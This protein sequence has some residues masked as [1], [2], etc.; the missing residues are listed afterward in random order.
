MQVIDEAQ[1]KNVTINAKVRKGH[2]WNPPDEVYPI[3]LG[4]GVEVSAP[5]LFFYDSN[6]V[7]AGDA[8]VIDVASVSKNDTV[9]YASIVG[10]AASVVTIGPDE[11]G[12]T[13]TDPT[14][15]QVAAGN[16][17]YI[18]NASVNGSAEIKIGLT[19]FSTDTTAIT[20]AGGGG[21]V[22]GQDKSAAVTGTVTIGNAGDNELTDGWN[23]IVCGTGNKTG[24]TITD[25]TLKG[26]TSSVVIEGQEN[27]DI[28]AED[29]ASITLN[30]HPVIGIPPNDAGFEQ[31]PDKP[32]VEQG[33]NINGN[34]G[35]A[36][37]L[38]GFASVTFNNGTVQCIAGD[39][40]DLF[41]TK[42]GTPT[43]TLN[44]TTIQNTEYGVNA[45]AGTAT[46]S[47][48]TIWY[49]YNGVQQGTDGTNVSSIDLSSGGD[50]GTTTVVC[51]N[52]YESTEGGDLP[53]VS[54]LNSTANS[55]NAANVT[56]DTSGPDLFS[57]DATM[58]D[59]TCEISS[60][61][62]DTSDGGVDGMDA[63]YTSSGTIN[64]T[65]NALSSADCTA[66]ARSGGCGVCPP[67]DPVCCQLGP[68]EFICEPI[69]LCND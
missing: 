17:L 19:E 62:L 35:A 55:L 25:A 29:F 30:S 65:G 48:S 14:T 50:G 12:N 59:C 47:S 64:T 33:S 44:S 46:I 26:G 60:C 13:P 7:D 38:N 20:V 54:V 51:S 36:V 8:A 1:A 63:V 58:A 66:P 67:L 3:V 10:A 6:A 56:W 4:W 9:G 52:S 24:C 22:L 45:F 27:C 16:T 18:A 61:T 21:L 34:N 5:G 49:N 2:T 53:G 15:I 32:D 31:C 28:D 37:L 43:L 69:G 68:K 41:A 39:A 23:G 57:C 40:F 42:A 11:F